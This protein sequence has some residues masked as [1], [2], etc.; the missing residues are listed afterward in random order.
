MKIELTKIYEEKSN[1][2]FAKVSNDSIDSAV[3]FIKFCINSHNE[4]KDTKVILIELY[5]TSDSKEIPDFLN[6]II[7]ENTEDNDV[8]F[9]LRTSGSE[10]IPNELLKKTF[11]IYP[12]NSSIESDE[13]S[14]YD[15]YIYD[16]AHVGV[17]GPI[18]EMQEKLATSNL[19]WR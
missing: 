8:I 14:M 13:I 5:I 3:R 10:Y 17:D 9:V 16:Y 18:S 19:K 15:Y 11:I 2:I 6:Y 1:N 4:Y 12:F 7:N